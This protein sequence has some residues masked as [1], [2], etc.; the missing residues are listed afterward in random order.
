MPLNNN[1]TSPLEHY[2]QHHEKP[3]IA[4][5]M[6]YILEHIEVERVDDPHPVRLYLEHL[7]DNGHRLLDRIIEQIA[8]PY[9]TKLDRYFSA[10][11]DDLYYDVLQQL[12]QGSKTLEQV[13]QDLGI[14]EPEEA[15]AKPEG[16]LYRLIWNSPSPTWDEVITAMVLYEI[17]DRHDDPVFAEQF[18]QPA[19]YWKDRQKY[20]SNLLQAKQSCL[21]DDWAGWREAHSGYLTRVSRA[22]PHAIFVLTVQDYTHEE[23]DEGCDGY[24]SA[25]LPHRRRESYQDGNQ[26]VG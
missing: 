18:I 10:F 6:S 22:W 23:C 1:E 8:R 19:R 21:D 14:P 24:G 3:I 26:V 20:W 16:T 17:R 25:A 13:R 2:G 9:D 15:N 11:A 4:W 12:A 7:P 5:C